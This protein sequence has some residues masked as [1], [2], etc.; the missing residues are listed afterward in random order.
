MALLTWSDK[1]SVQ[2]KQFDEVHKKEHDQLVMQ[3]LDVQKQMQSGIVLSQAVMTFLKT[4]SKLIYREP[5]KN[6]AS[7]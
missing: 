6:T 3:V 5:T 7:A 2:V 1:L 4:G